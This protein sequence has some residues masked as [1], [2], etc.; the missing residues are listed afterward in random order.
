MNATTECP[1]SETSAVRL[2]QDAKGNGEV[3]V[4][5]LELF[6]LPG[7]DAP[8][9][10]EHHVAER[11][12]RGDY[13][14][15][16][17]AV[18]LDQKPATSGYSGVFDPPHRPG[19]PVSYLDDTGGNGPL[20]HQLFFICHSVSWNEGKRLLEL[21]EY[22]LISPQR[23]TK[24]WVDE[25]LEALAA[26][27]SI[28]VL[29]ALKMGKFQVPRRSRYE[30]RKAVKE[31][32]FTEEDTVDDTIRYRCFFGSP[33]MFAKGDIVPFKNVLWVATDEE[34]CWELTSP[35]ALFQEAEEKGS[36]HW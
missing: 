19:L 25:E 4:F 16:L 33:I 10:K 12:A 18:R 28:G 20:Y 35:D 27:P 22:D 21:V 6:C 2:Y 5:R 3:R 34:N 32:P 9:C 11:T 17:E 24:R 30:E 23:Y 7:A 36:M 15:Q 1:L 13:T 31:G 29:P 26:D 14:P 8:A